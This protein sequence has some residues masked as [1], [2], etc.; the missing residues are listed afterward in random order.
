M[1]VG[2]LDTRIAI[3]Y[4]ATSQDSDYGT[5]V[6]TWTPL[7]VLWANVQDV[8]PSRSEAVRQ[9]LQIARNQTRVRYRYRSDVTSA[10]RITVRGATDRVLQIV[11]GPAE[12]GRHEYSECMCEAYT[13]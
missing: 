6:V 9:G 5:P 4:Q 2:P 13:S 8:M 10:M 7:A 12:L 1:N 11:G 3:E